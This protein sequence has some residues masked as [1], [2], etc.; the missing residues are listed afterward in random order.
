[1]AKLSVIV[2]VY[3][4]YPYLRECL[5]SIINQTHKNLEIIIVNDASPCEE[6]DIICKEYAERDNRIIY[7]KHIENKYQGGA[8]NTGIKTATGEYITFVDSDDFLCDI[9]TYQHCMSKI[10]INQDVDIVC[11]DNYM[12]NEARKEKLYNKTCSNYYKHKHYIIADKF[13]QELVVNKIFKR[14]L[15]QDDTLFCEGIK[16]E[17]TE[18][19]YRLNFIKKI[20]LLY[21]DRAY[22][23]YRY[24]EYSTTNSQNSYLSVHYVL[25]KIYENMIKY[26]KEEYKKNIMDFIN[27]NQS[28]YEQFSDNI[29]KQYIKN[30]IEF[31]KKIGI[32]GKDILKYGNIY[33]LISLVDDEYIRNIYLEAFEAY[34][35]I[36]YKIVIPNMKVYK[37]NREIKRIINQIKNL[38]KKI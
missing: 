3:N 31:I 15:F 28:K 25:F 11:F 19:W 35:K 22:Y 36:N 13:P 14:E 34:K 38:F 20:K 6:D 24:N 2:P 27:I 4:T 17:D 10:Y 5:D 12:L 29:K 1:M 7:I 33:T 16:F 21:I 9:N 26:K 23:M 32:S 37:F 30:H 18:F 8:R